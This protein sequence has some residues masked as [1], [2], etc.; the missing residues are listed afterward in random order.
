MFNCIVVNLC[1]YFRYNP[2]DPSDFANMFLEKKQLTLT[3]DADFQL[4]I[5]PDTKFTQMFCVIKTYISWD[6]FE[7]LEII[8]ERFGNDELKQWMEEYRNKYR[9]ANYLF[10]LLRC[11]GGLAG[12]LAG[13]GLAGFGLAGVALFSNDNKTY[14]ETV[15]SYSI[16][17]LTS[18]FSSTY[19]V[20][21]AAIFLPEEN[22]KASNCK[23][24][25]KICC[26]KQKM[27]T[28]DNW[29]KL[30]NYYACRV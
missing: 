14:T 23:L 9:A 15:G 16:T 20:F 27:F 28:A 6:D 19:Y 17:M 18:F 22:N 2:P 26:R 12:F 21:C 7:L 29:W 11:G 13:F 24:Q 4:I 30:S 10:F 3:N 25:S 5:K 8:I 1:D